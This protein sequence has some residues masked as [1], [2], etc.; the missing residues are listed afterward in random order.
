MYKEGV[1]FVFYDTL[2]TDVNNIGNYEELKKTATILS[3]LT[4]KF[5]IFIGASIQLLDNSTSPINL[6]INDLSV[7]KNV[8]EV[9]DTLS[10]FKQINPKNYSDYEYSDSD[11]FIE[12]H[13]LEV[14]DDPDVRYYIC[15]IDKNRAGAKPKLLFRLNLAYN[16]WVEVGYVRVKE[17]EGEAVGQ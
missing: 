8:K 6:T 9:F 2:K 10:L 13:D 14:Y 4:Q 16:E 11:R 1:D 17:A 15:V 3:E 5:N 7:S 12:C